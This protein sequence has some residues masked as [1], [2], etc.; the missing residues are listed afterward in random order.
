MHVGSSQ[1][2]LDINSFN[3]KAKHLRWLSRFSGSKIRVKLI[4]E[5]KLIEEAIIVGVDKT[6]ARAHGLAHG[7]PYGLPYGLPYF[8]DFI[9][10]Q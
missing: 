1:N 4:K 9:I 6:W 7:I 2:S 10:S 5:P 3:F 8:D